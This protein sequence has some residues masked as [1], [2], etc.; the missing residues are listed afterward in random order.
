M[1]VWAQ[2]KLKATLAIDGNLDEKTTAININHCESAS[3]SGETNRHRLFCDVPATDVQPSDGVP[4]YQ[5]Q[6]VHLSIGV[7]EPKQRPRMKRSKTSPAER[8]ATESYTD[9]DI[10]GDDE[11]DSMLHDMLATA[12]SPG[13]T[14]VNDV[15]RTI[16]ANRKRKRQ[17]TSAPTRTSSSPA[18]ACTQQISPHNHSATGLDPHCGAKPPPFK[19][20]MEEIG[21]LIDGAMRLSIYGINK[22]YNGLKIKANTFGA[23]LADVAPAL[24]RPGHLAVGATLCISM[25]RS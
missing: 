20:E 8:S 13:L 25:K 10:E 1:Q 18:I 21:L 16:P 12:S 22:P 3:A 24:W 5:L 23:G 4:R 6:A 17:R 9:H 15:S 7:L 11:S 2:L 14:Q 19:D